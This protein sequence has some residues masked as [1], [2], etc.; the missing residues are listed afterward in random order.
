MRTGPDRAGGR[1]RALP[2]TSNFL[3]SAICTEIGRASP[4][5]CRFVAISPSGA[6]TKPLP[7]P[8]WLP[9]RPVTV[10][11]TTDLRAVFG[12]LLDREVGGVGSRAL[13]EA[14]GR[15]SGLAA[16]SSA[17]T[18]RRP[19]A[20]PNTMTVSIPARKRNRSCI[21]RLLSWVGH[22]STGF[23]VRHR[24][25]YRNGRVRRTQNE[26]A[27]LTRTE[28]KIKRL[29]EDFQVEELTAFPANR[30]QLRTLPAEKAVDRHAGGHRRSRSSL[31]DPPAPH[32]VWGP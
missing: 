28:V 1:R 14:A 7:N 9:S 29:P 24:S 2:V 31:E 12:Q 25:I 13:G 21:P 20:R 16:G 5:T 32:L 3:P 26:Y 4:M 18:A 23:A 11:T 19:I 10:T 15:S 17:W 30:R 27:S 6:T 8:C 22:S